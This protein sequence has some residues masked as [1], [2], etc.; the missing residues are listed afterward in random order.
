LVRA[1]DI[2]KVAG[3]DP[4][5]GPGGTRPSESGAQSNLEQVLPVEE[6]PERVVRGG[7]A[8]QESIEERESIQRVQQEV[9]EDEDCKKF[10]EKYL[11]HPF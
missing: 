9:K 2:A 7:I 11:T 5:A 4:H 6:T 8:Q 1:K 10:I 3:Y